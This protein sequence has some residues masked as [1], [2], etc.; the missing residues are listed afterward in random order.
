MTEEKKQDLVKW[1]SEVSIADV[2]SVGGKNA[3][4]G[5]MYSN[6]IPLGVNIPDGF[7]LTA[8]AYRYF[9]KES[10]LDK[11]IREI[12]SNLNTRDIRNLQIHAKKV[13][14]VILGADLPKTLQEIISESYSK[15][16]DK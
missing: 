3:A 12:F 8:V 4:L 11:K 2:P 15:L 13:R 5:E 9:L 6:L 14:E 7:A 10:G 16:L 1:Y